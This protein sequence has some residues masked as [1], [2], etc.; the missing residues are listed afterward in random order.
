[1]KHT[2]PRGFTLIELLVVVAI[3][4]LLAGML[5][6]ALARARGRAQAISCVNNLKQLGTA[7]T[8]YGD[9][10][11]GQIVGYYSGVGPYPG[12][13]DSNP[14]WTKSIYPYI[15]TTRLFRDPAWPPN[16]PDIQF[17]YYLNLL[18]A[19]KQTT[20]ALVTGPYPL[21]LRRP[22]FPS[23]FI[24][25]SEDLYKSPDIDADATNERSDRTGFSVGATNHTYAPIHTGHSN[26]L[27]ADGHVGAYKEFV[28]GQMTY[29]YDRLGNWSTNS[30]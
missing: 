4:G 17:C 26:F 20:N 1:M 15:K 19:T 22:R 21:D 10:N 25:L 14:A 3:I 11:N 13:E 28:D 6:P 9:D 27:F 5:A 7:I 29:W 30:P 23:A 8:L 18:P 16:M 2:S 24:L 12:W